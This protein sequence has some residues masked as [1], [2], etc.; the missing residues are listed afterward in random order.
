M[1]GDLEWLTSITELPIVVKGIQTAEDAEHCADIGV[2]VPTS[3]VLDYN[4]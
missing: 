3:L 1:L 2:A 4:Y